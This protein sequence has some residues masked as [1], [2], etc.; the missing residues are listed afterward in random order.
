MN[1]SSLIRYYG[2]LID[3]Q[4]V[5]YQTRKSFNNIQEKKYTGWGADY[6][7]NIDFGCLGAKNFKKKDRNTPCFSFAKPF[8]MIQRVLTF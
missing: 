4:N 5:G 3:F 8:T 1:Q 6:L 2:R 7:K